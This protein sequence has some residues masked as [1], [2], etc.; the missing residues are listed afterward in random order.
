MNNPRTQICLRVV[1][2]GDIGTPFMPFNDGEDWR[3]VCKKEVRKGDVE[4]IWIVAVQWT[5]DS[6]SAETLWYWKRGGSL[7]ELNVH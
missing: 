2:T 5:G 4:R 1:F 7:A 6:R 3:E